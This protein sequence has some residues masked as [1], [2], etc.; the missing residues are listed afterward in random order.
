M[1]RNFIHL[2]DRDGYHHRAHNKTRLLVHLIFVTKYRKPILSGSIRQNTKQL[3]FESAR[4]HHWYIDTMETDR[5]HI[6]ILLQ[7][8][9]TVSV[10]DI[11]RALKQESTYYTWRHHAN[12]LKRHYWAEQ[13]SYG[14]MDILRPV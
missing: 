13:L 1:G 4:R 5:D 14:L 10:T 7:Y 6:H 8:P 9:P 11:V 2:H 3:I 12:V